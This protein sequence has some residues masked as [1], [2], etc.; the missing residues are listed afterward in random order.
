MNV[1][2]P[3]DRIMFDTESVEKFISLSELGEWSEKDLNRFVSSRGVQYLIQQ[4]REFGPNC[5][6]DAVKTFLKKAKQELSGELGGW[7]NAWK[8]KTRIRKRLE[9]ILNRWDYLV[10]RP[11]SIAKEYVPDWA[12]GEGTCYFLPGGSKESYSGS[13]GFAVNLGHGA[14]SDP[15]LMFLITRGAYHFWFTTIAGEDSC[16]QACKT[17]SEFVETFL[18]LTHRG[19]MAALVGV[20]AAGIEEQFFQEN[21][22]DDEKKERY[23]K[24]FQIALE[25]KAPEVDTMKKIFSGYTSPAALFGAVM[26]KKLEECDLGTNRSL[27]K[28]VL[29]TAII[30]RG[31]FVFFEMYQA[32]AKDSP[33]LPDTVW[34]AYEKVRR[35]RSILTP[36]NGSMYPWIGEHEVPNQS[37]KI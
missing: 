18:D 20:R 19:G 5:S 24:A 21:V 16:I 14:K 2:N 34:K 12:R 7:A 31:F 11:L 4:E 35:E 28:D 30:K 37:S 6:E 29:Y 26:A 10:A 15:Q 8:E 9:H 36:K 32:C 17:P 3:V 27:G 25:G 33:L 22:I 23:G 13:K 1:E